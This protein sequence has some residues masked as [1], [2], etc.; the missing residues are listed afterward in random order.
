[1]FPNERLDAPHYV[2]IKRIR[3][4]GWTVTATAVSLNVR[5]AFQLAKLAREMSCQVTKMP[6]DYLGIGQP[7]RE[8]SAHVA[9]C[10]CR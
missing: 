1:M 3:V 2:Y 4:Y 10:F 6:K 8:V 7:M 9:G 5:A